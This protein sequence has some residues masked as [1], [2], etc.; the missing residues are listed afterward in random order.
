[1]GLGNSK[2][3]IELN[4]K[5][6]DARTGK[7]I[8][9]NKSVAVIKPAVVSAKPNSAQVLD[10]FV[11]RSKTAQ[12]Q[13][14]AKQPSF[15]KPA[16]SN[17]NH[18]KRSV[19]KSK[20][21]MR[22]AVKKP[23]EVKND[24]QKVTYVAK[25]SSADA[26][27]ISRAQS[28]EK[29]HMVSKF[30][31]SGM[32]SSVKKTVAHLPVVSAPAVITSTGKA[33]TNEL[34]KFEHALKNASTHIQQLE[35]DVIKKVPFLQR[36]G[37]KNRVANVA[38]MSCAVLLL[39]GFFAYQNATSISM[40]VASS[41]TGISAKMPGY[42][43]AGYDASKKVDSMD[44]QISISFHSNTDAKTFTLTQQSSNWNSASLLANHIQK[45][46]CSTCYQTWQNEGK[47]V[48]IYDNSNAAWVDGGIWY[49]IEGNAS[50]TSDQLLRLAN[51][52]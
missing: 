20:A 14:F 34:E 5:Q 35:K 48:Y 3:T 47:T 12:A 51:S 1:M 7:I 29:S 24:I 8:G 45:R 42:I 28:T 10:G 30:G 33:V 26:V 37:F 43:P 11:R 49:Q 46:N 19:A 52:L 2:T 32:R 27:R 4:G 41:R 9:D 21:L 6:Y 23:A 18:S 44:G 50:L 16:H 15:S 25:Q 39:V 38:T 22:P 31:V 36:I 17:V 13:T 40:K